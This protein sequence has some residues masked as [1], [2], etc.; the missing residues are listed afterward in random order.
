MRIFH[1]HDVNLMSLLHVPATSCIHKGTEY[2]HNFNVMGPGRL[3]LILR[4][5]LNWRVAP[6]PMTFS[7]HKMW[8]PPVPRL[9]GP[10]MVPARSLSRL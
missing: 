6:V 7:I 8:V 2:L 9:W 5:K 3:R 4:I 10:G 1:N